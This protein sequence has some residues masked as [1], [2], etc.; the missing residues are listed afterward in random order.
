M[1]RD[2]II[3][4]AQTVNNGDRIIIK[5][6]KPAEVLQKRSFERKQ[7]EEKLLKSHR[8]GSNPYKEALKEGKKSLIKMNEGGRD[9]SIKLYK[10]STFELVYDERDYF[11]QILMEQ[12]QV[13]MPQKITE[14]PDYKKI[15]GILYEKTDDPDRKYVRFAIREDRIT[16]TSSYSTDKAGKSVVE[17]DDIEMYLKKSARKDYTCDNHQT[18]MTS[19]GKP[20]EV[21]ILQMTLDVDR[22]LAVKVIKADEK[23]A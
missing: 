11:R 23:I 4:I 9:P 7:L 15:F 1:T 17:Y 14:P 21:L 20:P 3:E 12:A 5:Y 6:R 10:I 18:G 19:T 2:K 22:I 8:K 13:I 16:R